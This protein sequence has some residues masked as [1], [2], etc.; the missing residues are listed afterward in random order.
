[1]LS[2]NSAVAVAKV[3]MIGQSS[4]RSFCPIA[5]GAANNDPTSKKQKSTMWAPNPAMKAT[6][7]SKSNL[8]QSLRLLP[9]NQAS[10]AWTPGSHS[11]FEKDVGKVA[12]GRGLGVL[13]IDLD[14]H[15]GD[16]RRVIFHTEEP[17]VVLVN[18]ACFGQPL[19]S[20]RRCRAHHNS[21]DGHKRRRRRIAHK[22]LGRRSIPNVNDGL[23][24]AESDEELGSLVIGLGA[25]KIPTL[26][27]FGDLPFP[28]ENW[29][30]RKIGFDLPL[31]RVR[32]RRA[33]KLKCVCAFGFHNREVCFARF[34]LQMPAAWH[35][36][37]IDAERKI[38]HNKVIGR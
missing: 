7:E 2:I 10:T 28:R 16:W 17:L 29:V 20:L 12:L 19:P 35:A 11:L 38:P 25:S 4:A 3:R 9:L 5:C 18:V 6:A 26:R 1:M 27:E 34:L 23:G 30:L 24:P 31:K 8:A 22:T 14:P 37:G 15:A 33:P 21:F 32:G 36:A 13:R